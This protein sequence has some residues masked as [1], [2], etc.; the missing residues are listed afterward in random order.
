MTMPIKKCEN[1]VPTVYYEGAHCPRCE[2]DFCMHGYRGKGCCSHKAVERLNPDLLV[3]AADPIEWPA[4]YNQGEI[5]CIDA[6][7]SAYGQEAVETYCIVNAFKYV[8][9][10]NRKNGDED[11]KKAIW[12]LRFATGDD[13]RKDG[14]P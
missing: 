4:H 13:P 11:L 7:L 2:P 3:D 1:H 5:E 8:W 12:Y 9:R 10:F 14:R 6:M